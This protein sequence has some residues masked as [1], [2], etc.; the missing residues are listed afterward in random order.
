MD[1][2]LEIKKQS[3]IKINPIQDENIQQNILDDNFVNAQQEIDKD[4]LYLSW[5]TT[6]SLIN[7]T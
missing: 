2:Q 5:C 7:N 1:N 3:T 6:T 4:K